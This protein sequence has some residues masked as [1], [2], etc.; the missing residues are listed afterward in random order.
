MIPKQIALL[1]LGFVLHTQPGLED[2]LKLSWKVNI[3]SGM[4]QIKYLIKVPGKS[5]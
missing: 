4:V 2:N 1:T 3:D 5:V